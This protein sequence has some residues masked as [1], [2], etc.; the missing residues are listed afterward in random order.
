MAAK[1]CLICNS[2]FSGRRDAKT[3]SP[4]CR[5]RLQ[6]VRWS[7]YA[8]P[9]KRQLA[10]TL[11]FLLVGAISSLIAIVGIRPNQATAATSDT[12]NFQSR[13]LTSDGAVVPDGNY[14]IEFKIYDSASAGASA[15]GVC[16]LNSSTDDCWWV[17][18][19][20]TGNLVRVVN[21]YF[22][23]N[24][25]SVTAFGSS[26]P[27]DQPLWL[28]MNIGGTGGSPSWDG[29]MLSS[30]NR[31]KLTGVPYAFRA[32]SLAKNNG[33]QTGTLSFNTVANSP[34]ITL[35][36]ASGTVCL[37]SSSSCGFLTSTTGVQLQ[38]SSPGTPQT[39]HFNISGTGI[40][41]TSL[42]TPLI[43][44]ATAGALGIANSTATAV[45]IGK[46]SSNITT[47]V[48][49]LALFKPSTG[50][51]STTAF[52]IQNA[53]G[54]NLFQ[55][56][57]TNSNITL[58]GNNGGDVQAWQTASSPLPIAR[59]GHG[60]VIANGYAYIVGGYNSSGN[61]VN[62]VLYAKLNADGT[63]GS[64][65]CQGTSAA[66]SCSSAT[67]TNSNSIPAARGDITVD[68][69]NGYL[70]A[71][72]GTNGTNAQSSVYYA[73]VNSDGTTGA[74]QSTTDLPQKRKDHS[75][76]IYNNRL[77]IVAGDNDSTTLRSVFYAKLNADG[78]VGTWTC[79]G[80]SSSECG[81]APTSGQD[82]PSNIR[83]QSSVVANGYLFSLGGSIGAAQ[84]YVQSAKINP[85]GSLSGWKCQK[86]S[87]CAGGP[88]DNANELNL[89]HDGGTVY[90]A[91][92][93]LYISGGANTSGSATTEYARINSDGTTGAWT[94]S[95]NTFPGSADRGFAGK[96]GTQINGYA[97]VFGGGDNSFTAQTSVYYTSTSRIKVAGSIDLVG[98][99][100]GEQTEGSIGGSLTAGNTDV[101]GQLS[102][103][104]Q[105]N[106][107]QGVGIA[108]PLLVTG[109]VSLSGPIVSS[110]LLQNT[111]NSN[112]AFQIQNAS[113]TNLVNVSTIST[114][115]NLVTNPSFE[116]NTT[117]WAVV[118][119]S[120]L[121][122]TS[123]DAKSGTQALSVAASA[124]NP[125]G[126]SYTYFY[127]P[128][129]TYTLSFWARVSSSSISTF[130]FGRTVNGSST[131]CATGQTLNTSFLQFTCTFTTG[132]TTTSAD[133]FY[134][135]KTG[136]GTPTIYI[137]SVQLELASTA[138]SFADQAYPNLMNNPDIETSTNGWSAKGTATISMSSEFA[139]SGRTSLKVVTGTA[140]N[141]GASY[142]YSFSASSRYTLSFWARRDTS[143]AATFNFGRADNGSDTDCLTGQTFNTTW[144]NFT[145][146]FTTGG[147]IGSSANFYIKQSD[148][149]T[150][151]IYIDGVTLVAGGVAQTYNAGGGYLQVDP[152]FSTIALNN[153]N[154]GEIQPWQTNA[155]SL[156]APRDAHATVTANGYVYVLG[157]DDSTSGSPTN[158][159][160]TVYY[161]KLNA[162]GSLGSFSTTTALP[163]NRVDTMSVVAN[164]Y[165][166]AIGG[167]TVNTGGNAVTTIYYAKLNADGTIGSW[168]TAANSL[169][170]AR[171]NGGAVVVNNYL[172]I[173]GGENTSARTRTTFY[174]KLNAD[175][176]VGGWK[177]E[178]NGTG[179]DCGTAPTTVNNQI[180][181]VSSNQAATVAN[182]Y[183]YLVGNDN[184]VAN[185]DIGFARPNSDG[186]LGAWAC[187]G[188]VGCLAGG[189]GNGNT[190][191]LGVRGNTAVALNGYLYSIGGSNTGGSGYQSVTYYAKLNSDGSTGSWAQSS[192]NLPDVRA[193]F[194]YGGATSNGYIYAIGGNNGVSSQTTAYY[195]STSRI[196]IAGSLDLVGT[197]GQDLLNAGS[198]AG[199]LTAGNTN[200]LGSLEVRGRANFASGVSIRD[201]LSV[202]GNVAFQ[203]AVNSTTAFQVQNSGGAQLL[204]IDTTNAIAD[205]TTN[206]N[207]NL[208]TNGSFE[209][210][211]TGWAADG[212][213]VTIAQDSSRTY[214]GN[215]S[216][217]I[218]TGA[219]A[220]RGAKFNL[221]T[222][223]LASN[224][225]YNLTL[226]ARLATG[227]PMATF[228]VGRA[229]NGSTHT[230]C[231]TNQ[232][233]TSSGWTTFNCTFTTG[234]TSSTPFIYVNQTD[235]TA[236]TFYIDAV[237]LTRYSLLNNASIEQAVAGNWVAL[238]AGGTVTRSTAQFY[239]GA[240][241]L[242]IVTATGAANRGARQDITLADSTRYNLSFYAV[243]SGTTITTMAAGYS[244]DG[245]AANETNC[246]SGQTVP[247][248]GG[249]DLGGWTLFNCTF[250]TPSTHSGTPYLYIK[251][252]AN[253]ARTWF[254]DA[255][256]LTL[257]NPLGAY[258]EGQIAL[259]G[260]IVSPTTFQNQY[261]ST[262]AFQ[263]QNANGGNIFQVDTLNSNITLNGAN[264]GL[265]QPWKTN[266]NSLPVQ[267]GHHATVYAN[268]YVYV[269]GGWINADATKAKSTIMYAKVNA[270]GS[271]GAWS[272]Q[273]ANTTGAADSC[274]TA[275]VNSN[276]LP[277]GRQFL[278]AAFANGY[279]YAIG[280]GDSSNTAQSSVYYAK[281]NA[282]GSTGAWTTT[283]NQLPAPRTGH[284]TVVANGYVYVIRGQ[285][286]D[287]TTMVNLFFA[288]LNADGSLGQWQ[289][290]AGGGDTNCQPA[291][292]INTN[293]LG[294]NP[295][296]A[297]GAFTANGYAYL[298]GGNN[299]AQL[300]TVWYA[301]LNTD[302]TT[303]AWAQTQSL[304]DIFDTPNVFALNGYAYMGGAD[305]EPATLMARINSDGT[306]GSW[307]GLQDLPS[308]AVGSM[309]TGGTVAVNG[310][311]Y[312]IG[313][314]AS[315]TTSASVYYTSTSRT[316]VAGSLDLVG[317]SGQDLLDV[318]NQ[319]GSLTAGNTNVLGNLGVRG[320][321]DISGST[322][323]GQGLRVANGG[324]EVNGSTVLKGV[325]GSD[326]FLQVQNAG[327]INAL[328]INT[329]NKVGAG[330]FENGTNA[331]TP[332]GW[333]AKGAGVPTVDNTQALFGANSMKVVTT[334]AANDG[335]KFNYN[336]NGSTQYTL[337]LYAKVSSGSITDFVVGRQEAGSNSNC[338]TGQTL[339]TTWTRFSCTFTTGAGIDTTPNIY[340][341]KSG[342][343]AETFFVDGVQLELAAAA[344]DYRESDI[345]ADGKILFKNSADNTTAFQI[346][347]AAATATLFAVDTTNLI[348]T[349]A[350][351]TTTFVNLTL[352]NAHFQSTQTNA[353]SAGT[354]SNCGG[355]PSA[356][357]T[358][359]STDSAG[360]VN[361]SAG[362]GPVSGPCTVVIT[363]NKTYGAAPKAVLITPT[364]AIG[365][366][367]GKDA[368]VTATS[369]TTFTIEITPTT[370]GAGEQ[371]AYYYWV[372]E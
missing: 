24:L 259:N 84:K 76:V 33:T 367:Q 175:G 372:V 281:V 13:L 99:G 145:C 137:D 360:S 331:V 203:N 30:G 81:T 286:A 237:Q 202:G 78:T 117:G 185:P 116:S 149:S 339:T 165:I 168:L 366:S 77:Y 268:G 21:G 3:C 135:R 190:L 41:G 163:A 318:N 125:S 272:C 199:S 326:G 181:F 138:T 257:N 122:T 160:T 42:L 267:R 230:S 263:V 92:G 239:D 8:T 110:V 312:V 151:N 71:V 338:L 213:G 90:T 348:I 182:G 244:F 347:N 302:G 273:G 101:F 226:S 349:I 355:T 183:I 56:D 371:N 216:L 67:I 80:T 354:P 316:Q 356:S 342:T 48:T 133:L 303:G 243:S 291:P 224:T 43:D 223:T 192:I 297:S 277:A 89:T 124:T 118:G 38:G 4:R 36:D 109:N 16:S 308:T 222:T 91:N 218:T 191:P 66:A 184:G 204:N 53:A 123:T 154:S 2:S 28:T 336:F 197:S 140:A 280:G 196:K 59:Q 63:V 296:T 256:Q 126:T 353:P 260:V 18:T 83:S 289:C 217:S 25:G 7:F 292:F 14:H 288:K 321:T 180:P 283:N 249:S 210:D 329:V 332:D 346:Q 11:L 236:R 188:A 278:T 170:Q 270:D 251:N 211:T 62:S 47:T 298:V 19:R 322:S 234:T 17:E 82:M 294:G 147:T 141:N 231:L 248:S 158:G 40:A 35:P 362:S 304:P 250:T 324:V 119:G 32:G 193:W 34:V 148:T 44:Q 136:T 88:A 309:G 335:A 155:N 23:V 232:T 129:T 328:N 208:V 153:N 26:I 143:S 241:S 240:A 172:Y 253:S 54:G 68:Y 65:S 37:Q 311:T 215:D 207:N 6:K 314:A 113:S 201:N 219:S 187:Q 146:T 254:A 5:K 171:K 179:N 27:W 69:A 139:N 60:A 247:G 221:T 144:T 10:K 70:Y 255:I 245:T 334:A 57:S 97:Y 194:G 276:T 98:I 74:W 51:D 258:Q 72:G 189:P 315:T 235:A 130:E 96:D 174:A 364:R 107:A 363:F 106:F 220:T 162:D 307:Q 361:I 131:N 206:G 95:S 39:G 73:K 167:A 157:G 330:S 357:V 108:G 105:A 305:G 285:R 142:R 85:D 293:A 279:L 341:I 227:P 173:L 368:I 75:A 351:N 300:S 176:S 61:V 121:S 87:A 343:S 271:L 287:G 265:L 1:K 359:G 319:A 58:N 164:G 114:N 238:A 159:T 111:V 344:T 156:P 333:T 45:N 337:S 103:R 55:V 127:K 161:A 261:N 295:G 310:Y 50:N 365:S 242:S 275:P 306:I 169:P 266:A 64:W 264:N 104:G 120:T 262:Y 132:A 150:D 93:Y 352:T 301:R 274:G 345:R 369:A 229:E 325:Q 86:S 12:L 102:V 115:Q 31:I 358:S 128:N 209:N 252:T 22:N 214:I 246:M 100:G 317:I 284:S 327:G 195:T 94:N 320:N 225:K 212:A 350:G 228:E 79:S 340:V 198:Q 186:S 20:T 200:I 52:R 134:L 177:C 205:L 9:V 269:I 282:D 15:Q 46:T 323:I 152:L 290:Q 112:S 49:G 178:S 166:Y 313:G 370:P 299:G 29:E 233:I